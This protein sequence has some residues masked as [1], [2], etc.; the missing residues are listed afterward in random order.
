MQ[1]SYRG[2]KY[3]APQSTVAVEDGD[4]VRYRGA[5]YLSAAILKTA[6]KAMD[7]THSFLHPI[8]CTAIT[9][10]IAIFNSD[11]R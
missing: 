5:S 3:T 8:R 11:G 1:L 9:N 10:N 2:V 6:N 7:I 4:V